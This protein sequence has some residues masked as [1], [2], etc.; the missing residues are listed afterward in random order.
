MCECV[1]EGKMLN[2]RK[3]SLDGMDGTSVGI[4]KWCARTCVVEQGREISIL[5]QLRTELVCHLA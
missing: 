2:F 1:W 5:S 4:A 3:M